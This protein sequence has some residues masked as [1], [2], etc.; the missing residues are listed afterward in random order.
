MLGAAAA[1]VSPEGN[2]VDAQKMDNWKS[3]KD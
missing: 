1:T 3:V 2:I